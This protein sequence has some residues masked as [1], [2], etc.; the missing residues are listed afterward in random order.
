MGFPVT[1]LMIPAAGGISKHRFGFHILA[2]NLD[3]AA[4]L[5]VP[6]ILLLSPF[7]TG[8]QAESSIAV[9]CAWTGIILATLLLVTA[10]LILAVWMWRVI[11]AG[12]RVGD[13][14]PAGVLWPALRL[15]VAVL[16]L[17]LAGYARFREV[18]ETW[19]LLEACLVLLYSIL[20]FVDEIYIMRSL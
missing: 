11:G 15:I 14:L 1:R 19:M 8:T 9:G 6:G 13:V 18:R 17:A 16:V 10:N 5:A 2:L 7:A 12:D 4:P 3:M 20:S